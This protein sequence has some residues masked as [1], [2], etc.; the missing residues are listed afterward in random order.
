MANLFN[1]IFYQP[2]FNAL[3]ILYDFLPWPD[4]GIA[5]ILLT[6]FIRLVLLPLFYK[7]AKDQAILQRLAPRIKE[8]QKT[9][10]ENKEEQ[11]K[12]MFN[13]YKEHKVNPFSQFLL[14]IV[15]LPVLIALYWVFSRGITPESLENL[16]SFVSAPGTVN[17]SFLGLI[18]L[19]KKNIIVIGLAAVA[20]YLQARLSLPKIKNTDDLSK[21]EKMSRQMSYLGPVMTVFF[22]AYLPAAIGLYWL[23][24]SVFSVIQQVI[25]NKKL[26]VSNEQLIAI[27]KKLHS[28]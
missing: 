18:D 7:G 4:L 12:A 2:L 23:T 10:K 15:Q 17:N 8:I 6:I 19:S 11:A 16:Y 1:Q 28:K 20:Q 22:L 26:K 5:I 25:I 24:T 13:L 3:V 9:H 21:K 14:L 27:D